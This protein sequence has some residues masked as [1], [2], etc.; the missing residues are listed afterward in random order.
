FE[1][2]PSSTSEIMTTRF[3]KCRICRDGKLVTGE[4]FIVSTQTGLIVESTSKDDDEVIDLGNKILAPGFIELQTNGM[5]GFHFTHFEDD[6]SYQK[7]LDEVARYLPSTGVTAFYATIPTVSSDDF[8]KV[9]LCL[10][11]S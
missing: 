3:T 7:K 2:N 9:A 11:R 10:P 5:R 4:D 1:T 6:A 8:K